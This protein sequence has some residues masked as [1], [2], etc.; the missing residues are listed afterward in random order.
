MPNYPL[1]LRL[2]VAFIA[3]AFRHFRLGILP[4]I[5]PQRFG[6]IDLIVGN[7]SCLISSE[8]AFISRVRLEKFTFRCSRF[9]V[10]HFSASSSV[11]LHFQQVLKEPG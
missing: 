7:A 1:R 11:I 3:L 5:R 4:D 9:F 6:D 8:I 10:R 2:P